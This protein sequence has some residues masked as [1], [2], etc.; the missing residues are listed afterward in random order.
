L[1][2]TGLFLPPSAKISRD[3]DWFPHN[4]YTHMIQSEYQKLETSQQ[5]LVNLL[6]HIYMY[7]QS[8]PLSSY[9]LEGKNLPTYKTVK[10]LPKLILLKF[11]LLKHCTGLTTILLKLQ[12]LGRRMTIIDFG[13]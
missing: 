4:E 12:W 13:S 3:E 7:S 9:Q 8:A 5:D 1:A 10:C 6:I 2:A 11:V